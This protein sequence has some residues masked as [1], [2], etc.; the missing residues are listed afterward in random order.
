MSARERR[1]Q[2]ERESEKEKREK[3][4]LSVRAYH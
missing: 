2:Q 3:E 1:G 4:N